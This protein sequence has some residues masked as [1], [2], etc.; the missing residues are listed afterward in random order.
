MRD[1]PIRVKTAF[2]LLPMAAA[3]MTTGGWSLNNAVQSAQAADRTQALVQLSGA[4]ADLAHELQTERAG[5]A[6]L[7]LPDAGQ[8]VAAA[9]GQQV[10]RTRQRTDAW[11]SQAGKI[12]DP[13][14]AI[15][16]II[17]RVDGGLA[18]LD[19]QRSRLA[20][21][22]PAALSGAMFAYRII[23]ADLLAYQDAAAQA[24]VDPVLADQIRAAA[25]LARATEA[26]GQQQVSVLQALALGQLTPSLSQD[27]ASARSAYDEGIK[28][29][30]TLGTVGWR[31]ELGRQMTGAAVLDAVRLEGV[32]SR[33]PVYQRVETSAK[34]WTA[35]MA[36][37]AARLRQVEIAVHQD[38][39]TTVAAARDAQ[40]RIAVTQ[41]SLTLAGVAAAL[42]IGIAVARTTTRRLRGLETEAG[43]IGTVR[44]PELKDAL[45]TVATRDGAAGVIQRLAGRRAVTVTGRDEI[46]RVAAALGGLLGA[47]E[48]A[49]AGEAGNRA[50]AGEA[51]ATIARRGAG[52]VEDI[53]HRLDEVERDADS[54]LLAKLFA[55]DHGITRM[56]RF[57]DNLRVLA[58]RGLSKI[59]S[60]DEDTLEVLTAAGQ[61]IEQ[62]QRI[63]FGAVAPS[64]IRTAAVPAVLVV[65]RELLD[66]AIQYSPGDS[67]VEV[68]AQWADRGLHIT[69]RDTG[70]GLPVDTLTQVNL[71]LAGQVA[72]PEQPGHLGLT[73][74]GIV[75]GQYGLPV[76]LEAAQPGI[77]ASVLV[78]NG[79]VV[80]M[81]A[82]R[83]PSVIPGPR[84]ALARTADHTATLPTVGPPAWPTPAPQHARSSWLDTDVA[85][86]V[87][88]AEE[89]WQAAAE[90]PAVT[91]T[92]RSGLPRR[93]PAEVARRVPPP[94]PPANPRALRVDPE[95]QSHQV[96]AVARALSAA[97]HRH[98][99]RG[100]T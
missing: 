35:A 48:T 21:G 14:A 69:V 66:N 34:A 91:G 8:Q 12:V 96:A 67:P 3:A 31:V 2:I 62:Y 42:L 70:I 16:A 97:H 33:T 49:L 53:I 52:L 13:P 43:L 65:L 22:K 93:D 81:I 36:A 9:Y 74:S 85:L 61:E 64:Q 54:E 44:L 98:S 59:H 87:I 17:G 80:R 60:G 95:R 92:T 46:G 1:L 82:D 18:D 47:A 90:S 83:R 41:G 15:T 45:S 20:D 39:T 86:P 56:R 76:W 100:D 26:V 55:V 99:T 23:V 68:S 28:T 10:E 75:A 5:L 89:P 40:I 50:A 58:E 24:G 72:Y 78:P 11:R 4:A 32:V 88:E 71:L 6:A 79:F 38:I 51:T 94:A 7:L 77:A 29:F 30:T 25:A 57:L 73:V 19:A 27:I 63:R 37:R 84:A